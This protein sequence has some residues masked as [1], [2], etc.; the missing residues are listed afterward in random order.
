ME[1]SGHGSYPGFVG[2]ATYH[3]QTTDKVLRQQLATLAAF[4]LYSGVGAKTTFGL[5]Q[6]RV[7]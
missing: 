1:R 5:G 6:M 2:K 3:L 4:G 7:L